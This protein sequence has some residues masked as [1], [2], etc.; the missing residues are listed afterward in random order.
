MSTYL[1]VL[2]KLFSD[3]F[4][5]NK[6]KFLLPPTCRI[7]ILNDVAS[8]YMKGCVYLGFSTVPIVFPRMIGLQHNVTTYVDIG[9]G[10]IRKLRPYSNQRTG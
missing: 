8:E 5:N 7:P 6:I 3:Q 1:E 9:Y 2:N 10:L 4:L